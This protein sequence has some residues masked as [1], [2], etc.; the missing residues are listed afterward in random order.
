ERRLSSRRRIETKRAAT[1]YSPLGFDTPSATQPALRFHYTQRKEQCHMFWT[2]TS[3]IAILSF[4]GIA[5]SA[6]AS[7]TLVR[8]G[9]PASVI[10]LADEPT[11]AARLAAKELQSW[12][13]KVSNA[14]VPIRA[15]SGVPN[16]TGDS[17][18]LVGDTKRTG[19]MGLRSADFDLEEIRIRTIPGALALIGDD[20]RPNGM[21]LSGTLWAV[22]TFVEEFLG[23]RLLWPGK[24]GEVVPRQT[25]IEIG[26][27]DLRKVPSL[28]QRRIRNVGYNARVQRGLDELGWS[29]EEFKRHHDESKP[30]FRFHR[31]G[32]SFK[33]QYGH[34]Y[35]N[36]WERFHE[37][38]PDWFA[39]QPDGTRDNSQAEE[40]RR[41]RLC[42]SNA[43]LIE[44]VAR[45]RIA[46][47]LENPTADTVSVS[48]NDGGRATF[49]QC[50]SCKAWDAPEGEMVQLW[51]PDG[52]IPHV[53][54]TDRYV[55]FY[56][57]VAEIVSRE[58]P[59]RY[60]G[61]YAYSFYK[62]PP[63][64]A[65]LHPNLVIG[66][67]GFSYLNEEA[68]QEARES[69]LKWSQAA[70]QLF[71]RPNLLTA[72]MGFPTVYVHRLAEDL[73]FCAENGMLFTDFD[74]CYQHWATNGLNYY[75]LA[76]LLWDPSAGVDA[77]VADYCRAG[78]GPAADAVRNYFSY[79]EDMTTSLA[80]SN[81]Y[82]SRKENQV[83][84]A[85]H[86]TDEHL[87][88][89][90]ALLD[91][92]VQKA[93]NDEMVKQRIAFLRKALDYA[94]VRRDWTLARSA[95]KIDREAAQRFREMEA[96]RDGWYQELGISWAINAPYMK[97]YGY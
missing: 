42:V 40:G 64:H 28:R 90:Q 49:C 95:R 91:E 30:W 55:K 56:S 89:C 65:K 31:I 44:Q 11:G 74:C 1:S 86:Y 5:T 59:D 88:R 70:R 48:P 20:E 68:R 33:G 15:E 97:F 47:M 82:K 62:S 57:A 71:L 72:G 2:W 87:A 6:S 60:L 53:S 51:G 32:G 61:A 41:A 80:L 14:T 37:D 35:G 63:V 21:E 67:V 78:F 69:W 73:R 52:P 19:A 50:E 92:A 25:T 46:A 4:I 13:R 29:D 58:F 36:Y 75:V 96:E 94:R 81:V 76:R 10:A 27:I 18:I 26:D 8:D 77:I 12:L 23:V 66:F 43:G 54:L 17:L 24:L 9:Q 3:S 38:H 79:L 85:Q 22:E 16:S 39:L 34:A 83:E 45:D 84:L 93:G 7:V